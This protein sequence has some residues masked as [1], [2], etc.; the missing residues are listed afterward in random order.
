[1]PARE[2]RLLLRHAKRRP[3]RPRRAKRAF[4]CVTQRGGP[5]GPG[6]RSAPSSASRKEAA[7]AAPAREARLL[8]RHAKRRPWRPRRAKRVFFCVTQ[9]GGPG[10]RR[11]VCKVRFRH[12]DDRMIGLEN[13][14]QIRSAEVALPCVE[15]DA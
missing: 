2:A 8:L 7:L 5:G 14:R 11:A 1:A 13:G 10:G 3:W 15:L 9:R 12:Y 6:A 4:F